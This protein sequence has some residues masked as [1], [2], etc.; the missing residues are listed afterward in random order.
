MDLAQSSKKVTTN[1]S[2]NIFLVKNVLKVRSKIDPKLTGKF[3]IPKTGSK[4]Y[5]LI[6]PPFSTDLLK[7]YYQ[8]CLFVDQFFSIKF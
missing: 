5:R 2:N 8:Q 6:F 1:L 7:I 4:L 3:A